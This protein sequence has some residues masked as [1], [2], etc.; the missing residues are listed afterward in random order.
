MGKNLQA[1]RE[2]YQ[3]LA[4]SKSKG[5]LKQIKSCVG[6]EIF[7]YLLQ[8]G[9]QNLQENFFLFE[10]LIYYLAILGKNLRHFM[11]LFFLISFNY[12]VMIDKIKVNYWAFLV[13]DNFTRSKSC[14]ID[15]LVFY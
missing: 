4:Y 11:E 6:A 14:L 12:E 9:Y 1:Q 15:D 5:R 8:H 13:F 3:G 10:Y 2:S 7:H